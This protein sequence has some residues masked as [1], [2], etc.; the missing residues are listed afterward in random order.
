MHPKIREVIDTSQY[1]RPT[2][3]EIGAFLPEDDA[4]YDEWL[5]MG[6]VCKS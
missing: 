3:R 4:E 6:S 2:I 1:C 5:K